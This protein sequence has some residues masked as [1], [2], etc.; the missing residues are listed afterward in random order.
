MFVPSASSTSF[1]ISVDNSQGTAYL[2]P[3]DVWNTQTTEL[4]SLSTVI[5]YRLNN[6]ATVESVGNILA[7]YN[8]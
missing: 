7:S 6:I 3:T 5:G 4:T 8:I 1:G 2:T